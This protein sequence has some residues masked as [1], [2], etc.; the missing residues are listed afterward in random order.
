[1]RKKGET[2]SSVRPQTATPPPINDGFTTWCRKSN[3][4]LTTPCGA[5]RQQAFPQLLWHERTADVSCCG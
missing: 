5:P 1:M 3:R 2:E 4:P